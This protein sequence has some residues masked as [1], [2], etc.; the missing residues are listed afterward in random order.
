MDAEIEKMILQG[1][2]EE[3]YQSLLKEL[4][5]AEQVFDE[6]YLAWCAKLDAQVDMD[7]MASY[8]GQP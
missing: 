5:E 4:A 7:L 2:D 1:W 6:E 8:Y 3:A